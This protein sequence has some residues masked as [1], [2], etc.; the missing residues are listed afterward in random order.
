M[1]NFKAEE[2]IN[3][4]KY[5]EKPADVAREIASFFDIEQYLL[6][7]IDDYYNYINEGFTYKMKFLPIFLMQEI[8]NSK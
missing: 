3:R 4:E 8:L 5:T 7:I 6:G 1:K 2:K